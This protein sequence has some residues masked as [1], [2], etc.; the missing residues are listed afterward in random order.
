MP[1]VSFSLRM[2]PGRVRKCS[3][4]WTKTYL[5]LK[6]LNL[7]FLPAA[8]ENVFLWVFRLKFSF[9]ER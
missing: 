9:S 7:K 8:A 2:I 5:K 3:L 6:Y 1:I 4:S